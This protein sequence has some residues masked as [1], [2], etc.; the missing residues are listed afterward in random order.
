MD[1]QPTPARARAPRGAVAATLA[2]LLL[3]SAG[4]AAAIE[5]AV[6][7]AHDDIFARLAVGA[8]YQSLL[9]PDRGVRYHTFGAA[10]SVELSVG[11]EVAENLLLH[12]TAL[13]WSLLHPFYEVDGAGVSDR[14]GEASAIAV[15]PGMTYYV[16]P[17]NL[18]ATLSIG[19]GRMF[20]TKPASQN[21][22]ADVSARIDSSTGWIV[23]GAIGKE[24]WVDEQW[25]LGASLFVL[26]STFPEP[27]GFP[28]WNGPTVGLRM[29]VSYD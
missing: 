14:S 5:P 13:H 7:Y 3:T 23:H 29:T 10:L 24:W 9:A 11:G 20:M 2:L 1:R 12:V 17:W 25:L 18:F 28:R 22:D 26:M 16:M 8:G 27:G 4:P 6:A 21:P 19:L 15:G